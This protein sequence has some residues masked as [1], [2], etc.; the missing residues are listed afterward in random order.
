M[1]LP[2]L[3]LIH[4]AVP[5]VTAADQWER[6]GQQGASVLGSIES[7]RST[8]SVFGWLGLDFFLI[9]HERNSDLHGWKDITIIIGAGR[10]AKGEGFFCCAGFCHPTAL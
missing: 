3:L 4:L 6:D 7:V 2:L 1:F 8:L 9:R 10:V 5:L